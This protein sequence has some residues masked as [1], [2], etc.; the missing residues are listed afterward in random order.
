MKA[1][2]RRLLFK[3]DFKWDGELMK[4]RIADSCFR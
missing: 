1:K 4:K 2:I 3:W